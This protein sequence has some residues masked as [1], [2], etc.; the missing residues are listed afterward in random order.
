MSKKSGKEPGIW[1]LTDFT[2][3]QKDIKSKTAEKI[4]SRNTF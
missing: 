3:R 2:K 4:Q 1:E